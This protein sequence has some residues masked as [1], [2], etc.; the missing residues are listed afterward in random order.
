MSE[1]SSDLPMVP[2]R[3]IREPAEQPQFCLDCDDN[4]EP[5]P[6]ERILYPS[7]VSEFSSEDDTVYVI[8]TKDGK[9]TRIGGLEGMNNLK[10]KYLMSDN[11]FDN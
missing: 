6:A 10:V 8:G 3:K 5:G 1:P 9:V 11:I 2:T 4:D 7:D